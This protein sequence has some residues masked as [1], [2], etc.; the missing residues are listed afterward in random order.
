MASNIKRS[1]PTLTPVSNSERRNAIIE[2][3]SNYQIQESNAWKVLDSLSSNTE[4]DAIEA[5]AEGIFDAGPGKFEATATVYVIL[6]Y[7]DKRES[8]TTT[9]AFPAHVT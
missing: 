3:I 5:N 1:E 9:D 4:V 2:A 7:G 8:L 6:N